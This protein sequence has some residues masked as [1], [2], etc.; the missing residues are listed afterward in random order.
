MAKVLITGG[1]SFS[2]LSGAHYGT[3]PNH[4]SA[5]L[6][7]YEHIATGL[8]AQ[9]NGLISRRIIY[10]VTEA[11]K[12]TAP[13]DIL[14]GIMWSGPERHD[15]FNEDINIDHKERL[16][17]CWVENP[18]GF[19][20]DA[21]KHWIIISP[22]WKNDHAR[23]YYANFHSYVG[24]LIYTY[25]HVLRIQWFLKLH[26]IRYFMTAYTAEVFYNEK[27]ADPD[28]VYTYEATDLNV[29]H[30]YEQIDFDQFLPVRGE[31]DWCKTESG[32]PFTD[33]N[34]GHNGHP[35]KEQHRAFTDRII[36]PF[37]RDKQYI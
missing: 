11:L 7:D 14:V 19:V 31:H 23:Q 15:F 10:A 12:T 16:I 5:N 27:I 28:I 6:P 8:G 17:D 34:H 13:K 4:L 20:K 24:G 21:E 37:L 32:I 18:T 2:E 30:L 35:N 9:G 26:G 22:S 25:E 1:C 3:W 29:K 33:S 36:I